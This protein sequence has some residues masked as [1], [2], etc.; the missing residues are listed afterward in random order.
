MAGTIIIITFKYMG[1]FFD[2]RSSA[3]SHLHLHLQ[4]EFKHIN[5]AFFGL[6]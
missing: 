1:M 2:F 6:T 3:I 4:R 5:I